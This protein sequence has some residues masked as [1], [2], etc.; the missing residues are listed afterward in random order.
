[1]FLLYL[2]YSGDGM[3]R[4]VKKK[5]F[6]RRTKRVI[7]LGFFSFAICF[8]TLGSILQTIWLIVNKYQEASELEIKL[9]D[10]TENEEKLNDEI[11]KLQDSDYLA[12][13]A[14]EK[15]FYSKDNE[16]IIRIPTE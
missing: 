4:V 9:A 11:V 6:R 10:L 1:M 7:V 14:R 5:K 12:R 8:V 3:K 15:Y 13:Y 16:I 2:D